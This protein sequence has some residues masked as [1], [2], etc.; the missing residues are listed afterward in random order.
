V[1]RACQ[2]RGVESVSLWG[3]ALLYV[4]A[5]ANPRVC[6]ALLSRLALISPLG[7]DLSD[8]RAAGQGLTET[9]D[10]LLA[11]NAAARRYVRR[12]EEQYERGIE[13]APLSD[14]NA[15]QMIRDVEEF[16]RREQHRG[17]EN[18]E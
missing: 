10:K 15:A 5:P 16:L 6:W 4:R 11:E 8:L 13:S 3:H 12:L 2:E 18:A 9:L 7:L 14:E 1:Q 17:D